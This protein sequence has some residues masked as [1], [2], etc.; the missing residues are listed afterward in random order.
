MKCFRYKRDQFIDMSALEV[1][2]QEYGKEGWDLV[3]VI[4]APGEEVTV[5]FVILKQEYDNNQ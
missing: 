5:L 4:R 2:L 3:T 1:A